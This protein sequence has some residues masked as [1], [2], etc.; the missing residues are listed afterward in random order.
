MTKVR[1]SCM[2]DNLMK[3]DSKGET[4]IDVGWKHHTSMTSMRIGL[5]NSYNLLN[6]MHKMENEAFVREI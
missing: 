4:Q 5:N 1:F 3:C 6:V 2:S